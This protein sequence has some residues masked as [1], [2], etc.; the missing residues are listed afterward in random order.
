MEVIGTVKSG[1]RKFYSKTQLPRLVQ[2]G[3]GGYKKKKK[4]ARHAGKTK[5]Y[6][7]S[8][9][10]RILKKEERNLGIIKRKS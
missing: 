8:R 10:A 4:E 1:W 9:K 6:K 2:K 7:S 3:G 5:I